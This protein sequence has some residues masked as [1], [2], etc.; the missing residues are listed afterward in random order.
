MMMT[1]TVKYQLDRAQDALR[2]ALSLGAKEEDPYLLRQITE[3]LERIKGWTVSSRFVK[4]T[5]E[6]EGDSIRFNYGYDYGVD[7]IPYNYISSGVHGGAGEDV[8]TFS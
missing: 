5:K 3:T 7:E 6:T 1:D 4:V 2:E 8:I